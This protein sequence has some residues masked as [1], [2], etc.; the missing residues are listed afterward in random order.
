MRYQTLLIVTF[1]ALAG[2]STLAQQVIQQPV[3]GTS[4]VNTTVS[5]PDRGTMS[6]GGVSSSQMGRSQYGPIRSGTVTGYAAQHSATT[7][8]VYIHDFQA[9]DEALLNAGRAKNNQYRERMAHLSSRRESPSINEAVMNSQPSPQEKVVKS[10]EL[11]RQAE[12]QGKTS[13]ARLHWQ[14]A[15]KYGSKTATKRLSELNSQPSSTSTLAR[16]AQ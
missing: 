8:S 15:A 1:V 3:V 2:K 14:M 10:E 16:A 7:A 12:K 4:A 11:A 13:V 9:M 6:L 5:V